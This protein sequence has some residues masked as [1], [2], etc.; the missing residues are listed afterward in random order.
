MFF[1]RSFNKNVCYCSAC[2]NRDLYIKLFDLF[3]RLGGD[4]SVVR[5][6]SLLD[7][8]IH[9]FKSKFKNSQE[10]KS[11]NSSDDESV[12]ECPSEKAINSLTG[13]ANLNKYRQNEKDLNVLLFKRKQVMKKLEIFELVLQ[14]E[15]LKLEQLKAFLS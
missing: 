4:L 9:Q 15:H 12:F 5:R 6:E 3:I 10:I 8:L 14:R 1:A 11:E 13:D 7:Q 2:N